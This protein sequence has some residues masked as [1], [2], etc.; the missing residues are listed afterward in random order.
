MVQFLQA[1]N[2]NTLW[3]YVNGIRHLMTAP[4]HSASNGLAERAV[5]S[6]K[7]GLKKMI[8]GNIDY[9]LDRFLF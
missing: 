4:Y 5:Q 9:K 6:L 3:T 7:T 8:N 1:V 2:S